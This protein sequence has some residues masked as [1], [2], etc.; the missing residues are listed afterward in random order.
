MA[1]SDLGEV[2]PGFTPLYLTGQATLRTLDDAGLE[3]G[4]V[5]SLFSASAYYRMLTLS[6]GEYSTSDPD[7]PTR[8]TWAAAPSSLT[9][10]TLSRR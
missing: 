1:K 6:I 7:T 3:K 4:D 8:R 10:S 9:S 5:D 2:G